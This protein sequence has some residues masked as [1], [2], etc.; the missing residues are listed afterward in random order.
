ML[1]HITI[2]YWIICVHEIC[3]PEPYNH[4]NFQSRLS[5]TAEKSSSLDVRELA[6]TL[7]Q[8]E[9]PGTHDLWLFEI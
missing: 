3:E 1:T 4:D 8:R 9:E 6:E 2:T 5:Q 7:Q